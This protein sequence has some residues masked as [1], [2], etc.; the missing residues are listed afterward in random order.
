M[1]SSDYSIIVYLLGAS[2]G[3]SHDGRVGWFVP[4]KADDEII[5]LN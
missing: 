3:S 2:W 5:T 1:W 4:P